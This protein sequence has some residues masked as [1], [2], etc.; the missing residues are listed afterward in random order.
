MLLYAVYTQIQGYTK[1]L[2][3]IYEI[4]QYNAS[5]DLYNI[6][7]SGPALGFRFLLD[8]HQLE[9]SGAD[10]LDRDPAWNASFV[11]AVGNALNFFKVQTGNYIEIAAGQKVLV[12]IIIFLLFLLLASV[13]SVARWPEGAPGSSVIK[14][15]AV[16][17]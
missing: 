7:G 11:L 8:A 9:W 6:S 13:I 2:N 12:F 16:L 17:S 15:A 14:G 1:C 4:H 5:Q 3:P 10:A